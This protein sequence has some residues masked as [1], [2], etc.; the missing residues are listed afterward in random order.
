M[1]K[2]TFLLLIFVIYPLSDYAQCLTATHG[3]LPSGSAFILNTCNSVS[4]NTITF[5][6]W[7]GEYS[8]VEI[9]N[10]EIYQFNS[11][12]STDYIT[13]S[14]NSGSTAL[15]SGT[16]PV[17]W[18]ADFT[19][20]IRFYTHTNA[21]CGEQSF[22]RERFVICG[23]LLTSKDFSFQG[24]KYYPNPVEG[25]MTLSAQ[26]SIDEVIIYNMIGQEVFKA[27]PNALSDEIDVS[28]LSKGAYFMNV[29]IK[30]ASENFKLIKN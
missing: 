14:D 12:I 28:N 24:F 2:I 25:T 29:K 19:G 22:G 7:A 11:S 8:L 20:N 1:K 16:T 10:G 23:A 13:I 26:E 5:E 9:N 27:F 21:A 17:T 3:Q 6:G 30:G 15:A 18:T 4:K